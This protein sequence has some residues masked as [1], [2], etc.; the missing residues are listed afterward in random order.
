MLDNIVILG[1][2][3]ANAHHAAPLQLAEALAARH[4]VLYVEPFGYESKEVVRRGRDDDYRAYHT[5]LRQSAAGMKI[6]SPVAR[7]LPEPNLYRWLM[8]GMV[9]RINATRI[10]EEVEWALRTL[11]IGEYTLL[12]DT[13]ALRHSIAVE[14]LSPRSLFLLRWQEDNNKSDESKTTEREIFM[15]CD[16]I[17]TTSEALSELPRRHNYHTFNISGGLSDRTPNPT[18]EIWRGAARRV[19]AVA[20]MLESSERV[21]KRSRLR[22]ERILS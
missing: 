12:L 14:L 6:L 18:E 11:G 22:K 16:A 7:L 13:P 1:S 5:S 3:L 19:E 15:Q 2:H 21:G 20:E 9:E 17:L 8:L 4:T 10:T